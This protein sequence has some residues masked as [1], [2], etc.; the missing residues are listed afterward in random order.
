MKIQR[1]QTEN[2]WI[3]RLEERATITQGEGKTL[4]EAMSQAFSLLEIAT[5]E[6]D[7]CPCGMSG[8]CCADPSPMTPE[9]ECDNGESGDEI[10]EDCY[11]L[12]CDNC[13][14][15]CGHEL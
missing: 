4:K 3:V 12:E 10:C 11:C 14:A 8:Q 9:H 5:K 2:G 15:G 1:T 13:G 7:G 6:Y